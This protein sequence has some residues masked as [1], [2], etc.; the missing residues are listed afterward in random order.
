MLDGSSSTLHRAAAHGDYAVLEAMLNSP[1]THVGEVDNKMRT[2]MHG[3][4]AKKKKKKKKGWKKGLS[5]SGRLGERWKAQLRELGEGEGEMVEVRY[6]LLACRWPYLNY[7]RV[8]YSLLACRWPYLNYPPSTSP[9]PRQ[10][11]HPFLSSSSVWPP[12]TPSLFHSGGLPRQARGP[13]HAL[14][15]GRQSGPLCTRPHLKNRL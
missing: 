2:A 7:P 3:E 14:R 8:R 9:L 13:H 1:D 15:Q 4:E 11:N 12:Q 10:L 6:S 5:S